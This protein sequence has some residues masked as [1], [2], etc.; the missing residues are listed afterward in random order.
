[1]TIPSFFKDAPQSG[2]PAFR[3][4]MLL[5]ILGL[6][7]ADLYWRV[8]LSAMYGSGRYVNAVVILM[9]LLNHLAF[10]F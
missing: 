7:A 1:M 9:L 4:G 5:A 2:H 10:Q 6:L 3:Y 8:N